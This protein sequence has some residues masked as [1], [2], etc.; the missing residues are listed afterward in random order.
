MVD[1]LLRKY[2]MWRG[3]FVEKPE[4]LKWQDVRIADARGE[5]TGYEGFTR[6]KPFADVQILTIEREE[7]NVKTE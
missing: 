5:I 1:N 3:W 2:L 6:F 7:I 4:G